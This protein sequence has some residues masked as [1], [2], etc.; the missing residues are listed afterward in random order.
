MPRC[1]FLTLKDSTGYVIDDELAFPAL[2]ALGW[3]VETSPWQSPNIEWHA[4]D[5]IVIRSTW[6]YITHPDAFLDVLG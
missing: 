4:Y 2:A 1:A 6:D 3:R 5:A